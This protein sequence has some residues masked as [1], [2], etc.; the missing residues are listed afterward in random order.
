MDSKRIISVLSLL[1]A[2]ISE[3]SGIVSPK[4]KEY[5]IGIYGGTSAAIVAAVEVVQ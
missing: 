2:M 3:A 4:Q 5:D 1:V